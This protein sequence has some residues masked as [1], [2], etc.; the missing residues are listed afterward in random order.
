MIIDAR[1]RNSLAVGSWK[2][3]LIA[4]T[5]K[6]EE[7]LSEVTT[8]GTGRHLFEQPERSRQCRIDAVNQRGDVVGRTKPFV[9]QPKDQQVFEIVPMAA[10]G[11]DHLEAAMTFVL[12]SDELELSILNRPQS[13]ALLAERIGAPQADTADLVMAWQLG[14]DPLE[15]AQAFAKLRDG[16]VLDREIFDE[17][18]KAVNSKRA[19][20]E[21]LAAL[22]KKLAAHKRVVGRTEASD[23]EDDPTRDP[24]AQLGDRDMLEA[25]IAASFAAVAEAIGDRSAVGAA[26]RKQKVGSPAD[27]ID[28]AAAGVAGKVLDAAR[29]PSANETSEGEDRTRARMP[30]GKLA[31]EAGA[32]LSKVAG[33][34]GPSKRQSDEAAR[35]RADLDRRFPADSFVARLRDPEGAKRLGIDHEAVARILENNSDFD[36]Q[37]TNIPAWFR[38]RGMEGQKDQQARDGLMKAQRLFRL[39]G[40]V[41]HAE[42]LADSGLASA[43]SVARLAEPVFVARMEKQGMAADEARAIHARAEAVHARTATL[44]GELR[45]LGHQQG[46]GAMP[47]LQSSSAAM[48]AESFPDMASLFGSGDACS[49]EWCRKLGSPSAYLV[50]VLDF[51]GARTAVDGAGGLVDPKTVLM[52]LRP[53]LARIELSCDNTNV[54]FP[55]IDL[56]NELMGEM[57]AP[58]A[59][60]TFAGPVA[61]GAPSAALIAAITGAGWPV[62]SS[63]ARINPPATPAAQIWA[64]RDRTGV[65][66]IEPQG[67]SFRVI[68]THQTLK[69]AAEL[70]A[71]PEYPNPG[72]DP[73]L[74]TS[75]IGFTLP[76]A[77]RTAAVRSLLSQAG[78]SR[79]ALMRAMQRDGTADP[80]DLAIATESLGIDEV[81]RPLITTPGNSTRLRSIFGTGST[82]AA[83]G[84][85]N[86]AA[87]MA[88]SGASY[89]EVQALLRTRYINPRG[90][91]PVVSIVPHDAG[92]DPALKELSGLAEGQGGT[93]DRLQRLLRLLRKTDWRLVDLDGAIAAPR[94]GGGSLDNGALTA[95]A[96]VAELSVATGAPVERIIPAFGLIDDIGEDGRLET[97]IYARMFLIPGADGTVEPAFHPE[98]LRAN[99]ALPVG[100]PARLKFADRSAAIAFAIGVPEA[101]IA[102]LAARIAPR[103]G[104]DGTAIT[105]RGLAEIAAYPVIARV[106]GTS[107]NDL[108]DQ[109][110]LIGIDPTASSPDAQRFLGEVALLQGSGLT[111]ADA[112]FFMADTADDL[113]L[114]NI[115]DDAITAALAGLQAQFLTIANDFPSGFDAG[116]DIATNIAALQA[117]GDTLLEPAGQAL[118]ALSE[119]AS[120]LGGVPAATVL[121]DF[122]ATNLVDP[123]LGEISGASGLEALRGAITTALTASSG[124]LTAAAVVT[125]RT[126]FVKALLDQLAADRRRRERKTVVLQM[127]A[128]QFEVTS[129][130]A[131]AL[132]GTRLKASLGSGADARQLVQL[133]RLALVDASVSPPIATAVTEAALAR[134]FEALRLLHKLVSFAKSL[135]LTPGDL[136]AL[137]ALVPNGWFEPDAMKIGGI[138]TAQSWPRLA[139]LLRGVAL[140]RMHEPAAR[141]APAAP[142]DYWSVRA[143]AAVTGATA[144]QVLT[145]FAEWA[146]LDLAVVQDLDTHFGI[147]SG[148]VAAGF[149]DPAV[150][151][152]L[153][154]AADLLAK[155]RV[156]RPT[157]VLLVA[158]SPAAA[159]VTTIT[160]ALRTSYDD[161]TWLK[162]LGSINDPLRMK[163]RDAMIAYLIGTRT[164]FSSA[165]DLY[166][167]MMLDPQFSAKGNTSR[168]VGAH[169]SVQMF[170][171]RVRLGIHPGCVADETV[172][173]KWAQWEWMSQYRV[174]EAAMMVFCHPQDYMEADL[175]DDNSP[176]FNEL[177]D[178][179]MQ[180][181]LGDDLVENA[182]ANYLAKLDEVARLEVVAAHYQAD[183]VNAMH[184][185]ARTEGGDPALYFMRSFKAEREWTPWQKVELEISSDN[186][187]LFTRRGRLSV[188]WLVF[189]EEADRDQAQPIPTVEAEKQR[190]RWRI[191]LATSDYDG[192]K[193]STRRISRKALTTSWTQQMLPAKVGFRLSSASPSS[194]AEVFSAPTA[195]DFLARATSGDTDTLMVSYD[196]GAG[197][198][199][200]NDE[201]DYVNNLE[202]G[203]FSLS[204]CSGAPEP[205]QQSSD[206]L[207]FLPQI[208]DSPVRDMRFSERNFDAE[209]D[210]SISGPGFGLGAFRAVLNNTPDN[211]LRPLSRFR[212]TW[213]MQMALLDF[214]AAMLYAGIYGGSVANL[215]RRLKIMPLGTFMPFF[216]GDL[217]RSY[218]I[219]PGL[220]KQ[221]G[222]TQTASSADF[223]GFT[224]TDM[225]LLLTEGLTL[226]VL[227]LEL[228]ETTPT[229]DLPRAVQEFFAGKRFQTWFGTMLS[230]RGRRPALRFRNFYHPHVCA[231]RT[232]LSRDGVPGLINRNTQD[233]LS[234][235]TFQAPTQYDPASI[236]LPDYPVEDVDFTSDGAYSGYNW[237][238]FF[239]LPWVVGTR[240]SR[241]G[242]YS[243]ARRWFELVFDPGSTSSDP[244][245]A[246]YWVTKPFREISASDYAQQR[247]E[248][249]IYESA[250]HP[251]GVGLDSAI[252]DPIS[253]WRGDPFNPF[254]IARTRITAFQR[255]MVRQTAENYI[256][257]ADSQFA[258]YQREPITFAEQLYVTVQRILGKRDEMI[259]SPAESVPMT[260]AQIEPLTDLLGNA[261]IGLENLVSTDPMPGA[262]PLTLGASVGMPYFCTPPSTRM[263][264]LRDLVAGRLFNIRN[265]RNIDGIE[266]PLALFA[267]PIDPM[268]L[269]RARAAGLSIADLLAG[270]GAPLPYYRF[271]TLL[272]T[273]RSF[274][275]EARTLSS[276]LLAALEKGD[277][278]RLSVLRN[279]HEKAVA[280]AQVKVKQSH[281]EECE[282]QLEVIDRQKKTA[283]AR[284]D[285]YRNRAFMSPG[286][287]VATVL[288]GLALIP[289]G[290]AA[291]LHFG[292]A[293][294]HA[295][296][297]AQI[298]ASGV[299]GSPHASVVW[300]S[301]NIAGMMGS[302]AAGLSGVG[303][304]M[305]SGASIAAT[306]A[307]YQRRFEEW[308][309]NAEQEDLRLVEIEKQRVAAE[310]RLEMAQ[311]DLAATQ[312]QV[313]NAA[314]VGDFLSGK[315]TN[316]AL[317]D[318]MVGRLSSVHYKAFKLAEDQARRASR[319]LQA[320]L[321][322]TDSFISGGYWDGAHKG[323]LAG[324]LL[325]Q[326]INAMESA[327][328]AKNVRRRELTKSISLGQLDPFALEQLRSTGRC[329]FSL[330]EAIFDM[331][332]PG[333]YFR[334]IKTVSLTVPCVAGPH[335]SIAAKL[336]LTN[337]RYRKSEA[338]KSGAQPWQRYAAQADDDR[339][340]SGSGG[341]QSIATS[342]AQND[343]GMFEMRLGDERYLPFENAGAESGWVL[344]FNAVTPGF[345][346]RTITDVQMLMRYTAIDGKGDFRAL[347]EGALIHQLETM[348]LDT[349]REGLLVAIDMRR[350]LPFEWKRLKDTGSASIAFD[351]TR[352]PWLAQ[353][354]G[355]TIV[356]T[357]MLARADG[358]PASL[359][360]GV[361]GTPLSLASIGGVP[362]LET[363]FSNAFVPSVGTPATIT[364]ASATERAALSDL[365]IF[366]KLDVT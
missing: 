226:L 175:R 204:G 127:I 340:V 173:P 333:Q 245:P 324:D 99:E 129:E 259:P 219:I 227:Y 318:W 155:L 289:N 224:Y 351:T 284:R 338:A 104:A 344:E 255:A 267:P 313:D 264:E 184:V 271:Q 252:A 74:E 72:V 240:L 331:D 302:L 92:C 60:P 328:L 144:A 87:F 137:C 172:D 260:F 214:L 21:A 329:A 68:R 23:K 174:Y 94:L 161:E 73:L 194:I 181:E 14:T 254:A 35:M 248:S 320:E 272:S 32:R 211:A 298:G 37:T 353:A 190:K 220:Y 171:N 77:P 140:Q 304:L 193:W 238:L 198:E 114:R 197:H 270:F 348:A 352:L 341:I 13:M 7:I 91:A 249:I 256:N 276:A 151:T 330:P 186:V 9:S 266:I 354:R 282:A 308:T 202:I 11:W 315:F 81:Q 243:E 206:G 339:F 167:H 195:A 265:S 105:R 130:M 179:L 26:L 52:A 10:D 165:D 187:I 27:L 356:E 301:S 110:D 67:G 80:S 169:Q 70:R 20:K 275:Q 337:D 150:F 1:V 232:A 269:V 178:E 50:D 17:A 107:L 236:V 296:P 63:E 215:G 145:L 285:F 212:V 253:V 287:I 43:R 147:S 136:D 109:I 153:A 45:A 85:K 241:A 154:T 180:G 31:E 134:G 160:A 62:P 221:R 139:R 292:A 316:T 336:T 196:F 323:L 268:A 335:A 325:L 143:A 213:P 118:V 46:G 280:K 237:E 200:Q 12:D 274:A 201:A 191:Q 71:Q 106:F 263:N 363:A 247:I 291:A 65:Y 146:G 8:E 326:D 66:H 111:A 203:G 299:G 343:S 294:V 360:V 90:A 258:I 228:I 362:Y 234:G 192:R 53:D 230:L 345:D 359:A 51:L 100:D 42:A 303:G 48:L 349:A 2:I 309:F 168:I 183:G 135:S 319:C 33:A 88:A 24:M 357:A 59:R 124:D 113:D 170:I 84:V 6:G 61:A 332:H 120:T 290:A 79:L 101:D 365:V 223:D 78:T 278:E 366:A 307:G 3:R 162:V 121:A 18:T 123:D 305:S 261:M 364:M 56:A 58:E 233:R 41:A 189:A 210:L 95:M 185:L 300:G 96:A 314:Q 342:T 244:V 4:L 28:L 115:S 199:G 25:R 82:N 152:R 283:E 15:R 93:L 334:R 188:A 44:A 208:K 327:Y 176:F 207:Y 36:I 235:F 148:G 158:P 216:F 286:E 116:A 347:V 312:L 288:N 279:R 117:T 217:D 89:A 40:S 311:A 29:A 222:R 86:L 281:I 149:A 297:N 218:V 277:A 209:N 205:F 22:G 246:R 97:S 231:L 75:E 138:G 257:W 131:R 157:A 250:E 346:L 55:H 164:E 322:I 239:H 47:Q 358:N 317:Y 122:V 225:N 141:P 310:I 103:L 54:E 39:G 293:A 321:G 102:I 128:D 34:K 177:L 38:A 159:A 83:T 16:A 262:P 163:L 57:I 251:G 64:L 142:I 19:D 112:R 5:L 76:Y 132:A 98:A 166:E 49:C 295:A 229:S 182:T 242:R 125:A 156:D 361:D 69:T 30:K 273:A 119:G 126:A 108:L 355:A 133:E 350:D 306:I